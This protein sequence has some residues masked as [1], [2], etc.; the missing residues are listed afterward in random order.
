MRDEFSKFLRARRLELGRTQQQVADA[1]GVTATAITLF[2]QGRRRPRLELVPVLADVLE[3]D[4]QL[5]C[6]LA[7]ETR[8]GKFYLAMGE[9]PVET[10]PG[11]RPLRAQEASPPPEPGLS[12]SPETAKNANLFSGASRPSPANPPATENRLGG[13][14]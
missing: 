5:L 8:A 7:L 2:E 9:E 12:S 11:L 14:R 1:C 3:V 6:R 4:R 13:E 10:A